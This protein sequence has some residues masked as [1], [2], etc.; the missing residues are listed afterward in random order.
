[1]TAECQRYIF[2]GENMREEINVLLYTQSCILWEWEKDYKIYW[3]ELQRH[4][5]ELRKKKGR[6][7]CRSTVANMVRSTD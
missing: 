1:L 3:E 4:I 5:D 7:I 6:D 2:E